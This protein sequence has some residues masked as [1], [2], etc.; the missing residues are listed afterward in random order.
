MYVR[1]RFF[2]PVA[3]VEMRQGYRFNLVC[4]SSVHSVRTTSMLAQANIWLLVVFFW[5]VLKPVWRTLIVLWG[6]E[7]GGGEGD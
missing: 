4:V 6:G 2:P 1:V 7:W 3:S 5:P